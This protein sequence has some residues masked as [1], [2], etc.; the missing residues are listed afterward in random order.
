V[1]TYEIAPRFLAIRK[2][3]NIRVALPFY[4]VED[5]KASAFWLQPR[6]EYALNVG[7][8]ALLAS[9]VKLAILVDDFRDVGLEV[10]D[11]SAPARGKDRKPSIYT[12]DSFKILSEG[13]TRDKLQLLA[14]AYDRVVARG[15]QR[16]ERTPK[17]PPASGPSLF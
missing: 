14:I 6:K 11:M 3:L 10:C 15:V 8:L 12:L 9:M 5:G 13:E 4:F 7:Q 16:S 17:R 2:D 1:Q